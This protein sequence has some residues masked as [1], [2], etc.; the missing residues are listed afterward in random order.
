MRAFIALSAMKPVGEKLSGLGN[1]GLS[2]PI[3]SIGVLADYVGGRIKREVRPDR[4]TRPTRSSS[5]TP[6]RSP[7]RSRSSTRSPSR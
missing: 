7:T 5:S 1:I 3:G 6:T 4:I 2:D